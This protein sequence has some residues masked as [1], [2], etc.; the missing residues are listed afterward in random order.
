[1][2]DERRNH[3]RQT[4]ALVYEA[5]LRLIDVNRV[6]WQSRNQFYAGGGDRT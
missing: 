5:Y 6:D 1:M 3:P 4:T 2:R